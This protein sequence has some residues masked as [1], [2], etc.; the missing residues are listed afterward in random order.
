[1]MMHVFL[2][3]CVVGMISVPSQ[4]SIIE[5]SFCIDWRRRS[6]TMDLEMSRIIHSNLLAMKTPQNSSTTELQCFRYECVSAQKVLIIQPFFVLWWRLS[7]PKNSQQDSRCL[8]QYNNLPFI[9]PCICT[10][11][12]RSDHWINHAF[13]QI[14]IL[15]HLLL[16]KRVAL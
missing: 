13:F 14:T 2:C 5:G 12:Y 11:L 8:R 16:L 6:S 15:I 4:C 7:A 3:G 1:M 9:S 10:T